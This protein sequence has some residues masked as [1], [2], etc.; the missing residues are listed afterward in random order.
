MKAA[1]AKGKAKAPKSK[2]SKK[3]SKPEKVTE[4]KT[5]KKNNTISTGVKGVTEYGEAKR[6]FTAESRSQID[7]HQ[8]VLQ[9]TTCIC[10]FIHY[11]P[12]IT[13]VSM[14]HPR[15]RK[16]EP[17]MKAS[18]VEGLWRAST[19][20]QQILDRMSPSEIKRRRFN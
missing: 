11:F 14:L 13:T 17:S 15:C 10:F 1:T 9:S 8:H 18:V 3:P 20:R 6:K 12:R 5:E 2:A 19:E 7:D 16:A 4:K